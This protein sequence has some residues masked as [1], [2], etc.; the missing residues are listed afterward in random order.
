[1][2]EKRLLDH[3]LQCEDGMC[4]LGVVGAKRGIDLTRF[5]PTNEDDED[6]EWKTVRAGKLVNIAESLAREITYV[7]DDMGGRD[8]TPEQRWTR[9]RQWAV[10][11]IGYVF[12]ND[13]GEGL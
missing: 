7:N 4:A 5:N 1:M 6:D 3:V 13:L 8:E 9:V 12:E 10:S 2:P 11:Q